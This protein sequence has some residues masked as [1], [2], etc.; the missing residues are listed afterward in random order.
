MGNL[1]RF[2]LLKTSTIEV[3]KSRMA[4]LFVNRTAGEHGRRQIKFIKAMVL[5]FFL[6]AICFVILL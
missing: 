2:K 5:W 1:V 4:D 3:L 6:L